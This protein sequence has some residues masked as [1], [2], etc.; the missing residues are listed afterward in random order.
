MLG[1]IIGDLAGSVYEYDEFTDKNINLKRRLS[2]FDKEK[3]IDNNSF[4]SDD[5]ILTIAILNAI[6]N[7]VSYEENLKKYGLK[8]YNKKPNTKVSH[9]K[10][11][12]SPG[13]IKWCQGKKTNN[14]I[15][16]GALMRISPVG[17]L[18]DNKAKVLEE[19]EK[20]TVPSHNTKLALES[21]KIV[22]SIIFEIRNGKSKE[23]LK[24]MFD[25][26]QNYDLE[27]L[28]KNNTFDST[29]NVLAKCLF[30]LFQ[31]NSFEDAI[32]KAISIGGDTDTVAA[33]TG[34]M[35]EA[36]Y[37]ID[38]NLQELALA[39]LPLEFQEDLIRGYQKIKRL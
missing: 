4:Y 38:D 37:G 26:N 10:Y 16:N 29:C 5:T 7:N 3:L 25:L 11:M 22:T 21:S 13:F 9:F 27:L 28:Q 24:E 23:Q 31:S 17:Y 34:S 39:K 15:G 36:L 35:A 19:T 30:I 8:Y 32:R 20:A 14:S 12:F 18:F 2:I 33:I 6:L 1:A